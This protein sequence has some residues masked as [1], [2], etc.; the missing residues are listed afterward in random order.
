[1]DERVIRLREARKLAGLNQTEMG[2]LIGISLNMYSMIEC[3]QRKLQERH[4]KA[5]ESTQI[6][7][8]YVRTGQGS[9]IKDARR[10]R[11]IKALDVITP[12][13]RKILEDLIESWTK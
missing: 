3:G 6:N 9:P 12:E 1:M 11:F 7:V 13:Q 5:L 2:K 4:L 10:D 8:N